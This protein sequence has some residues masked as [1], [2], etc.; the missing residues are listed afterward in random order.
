[1]LCNNVKTEFEIPTFLELTNITSIYK[2]RGSKSDLNNDRG[3]FNVMTVRSII[4]NLIYNEY[5]SI[6]D[7]NMSDSN[8]GGRKSRNIR[9]NLFI[10]YGVI[11][12]AIKENLEVDINLYDI[13]KCFASMWFEETMND[14]WDAGVQDDKFAIIAKMNEKCSVAVKTPVGTTE[15]FQIDKIEMQGT[16]F[17]N[18]KCSIQIDTLGKECYNSKE[19]LF[20]YK[21]AVFVP[22]LGMIDDICSFALSGSN[23]IVTNAIINS[24]IES[25]K[26][27][28]GPTKCYNIHIGKLK[29]THK[30]L[31]VHTD[32]LNVKEYE[33][34]LGDI[35]TNTGSNDKNIEHRKHEGLAAISQITS[36]LNLTS[37][38]HYHFE[39]ALILRESI[40]ISKLVF[41][42]EVWYN[43][44]KK[45]LEQL[46]QVDEAYFRRIL[47]VAKTTPKAGLY[48]EWGVMPVKFI[49]KMRRMLY[50]WHI[51]HRNKNEL[52]FKFFSA[53]KFSPS[54]GDWFYQIK[55]DM[56]ELKLN[57]SEEEIISMSHYQFKKLI[58]HK[59]ESLAIASLQSLKKKKSMKLNIKKF[60]PQQ[61]LLSRNLSITEVQNLFKL[62][63]CMIDV[64]ENFKSSYEGNISCRL[65]K[66]FSE[67]QQHL[68]ECTVIKQKLRGVVKFENLNIEMAHQSLENQEILAKNYTIILN[69]RDDLLSL[70]TGNQ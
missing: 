16:K 41:N 54:K 43:V 15:R 38:G 13:A 53:Q 24:K 50:Y 68:L 36:I 18:I 20:L 21:N 22:P 45:Q 61:Y 59:V 67:S 23:A 62:R 66:S 1:M 47:N 40:L 14:L 37:L 39:I 28:F 46:E 51:L 5:Y 69:T 30:I 70:D 48:M 26:L 65:C 31:K 8:V 11:N 12:F 33:T 57:L 2:N 64:K 49:V 58:R 55:T 44:T 42:S 63:N 9:D 7:N 17:S 25:K 34:Y 60:K 3:V 19:G 4:D 32:M 35:I 52:L 6:I 56:A 29:D 10:V 27:D